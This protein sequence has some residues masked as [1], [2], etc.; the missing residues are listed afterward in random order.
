M[1]EEEPETKGAGVLSF[2][3]TLSKLLA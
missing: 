1:P 2:V 3:S